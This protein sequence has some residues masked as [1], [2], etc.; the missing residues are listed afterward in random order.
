MEFESFYTS[1]GLITDS[2]IDAHAHAHV[3]AHAHAYAHAH[4]QTYTP[5]QNFVVSPTGKFR[6]KDFAV[7]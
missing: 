5:S 2:V 1:I 7:A 3:H 4:A 6:Q